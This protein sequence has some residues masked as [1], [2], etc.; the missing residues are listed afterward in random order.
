MPKYSFRSIRDKEKI[1]STYA[2]TFEEALTIF[3]K[4]KDLTLENFLNLY[5]VIQE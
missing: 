3:S 5:E 1:N 4:R 2:S